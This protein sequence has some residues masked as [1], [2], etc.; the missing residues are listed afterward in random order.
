MARL[1]PA[2]R[3]KLAIDRALLGPTCGL[4]ALGAP[5]LASSSGL[6][7]NLGACTAVPGLAAPRRNSVLRYGR[8][9]MFDPVATDAA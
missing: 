8:A 3:H 9:C 5:A 1:L 7:W 4:A 2:G 6:R